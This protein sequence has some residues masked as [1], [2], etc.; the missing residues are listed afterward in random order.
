[1]TY[2]FGTPVNTSEAIA[3]VQSSLQDGSTLADAVAERL[4]PSGDIYLLADLS[5][6]VSTAL[7]YAQSHQIRTS[8]GDRLIEKFLRVVSSQGS[9]KTLIVEDDLAS[10]TDS[11]LP[12]PYALIDDCVFRWRDLT[13]NLE[14]SIRLLRSR[15]YPLNAFLCDEP[16]EAFQFA[17]G[18]RV[19]E[20]LEM[21]ISSII[22]VI[23]SAFDAETFLV[24]TKPLLLSSPPRY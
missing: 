14:E 15:A 20:Q 1:V 8:D 6:D 4:W 19:T 5:G 10:P 11:F 23:V 9:C 7:D 18:M 17:P 3:W 22:A 16:V 12:A 13:K 24:Y 2:A 21:I